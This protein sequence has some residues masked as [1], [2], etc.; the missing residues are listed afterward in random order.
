MDQR[1]FKM[2]VRNTRVTV[3]VFAYNAI[4]LTESLEILVMAFV[5]A[6]HEGVEL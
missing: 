5:G 2:T 3:F 1:N 4:I 6:L